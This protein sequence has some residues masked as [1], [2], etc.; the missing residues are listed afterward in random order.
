MAEDQQQMEAPVPWHLWVDVPGEGVG[1][2]L[3]KR[4]VLI[5]RVS[6]NH[7]PPHSGRISLGSLRGYHTSDVHSRALPT[8]CRV[9]LR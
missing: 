3:V 6:K 2:P 9:L 1:I 7:L 8:R 4:P 5:P